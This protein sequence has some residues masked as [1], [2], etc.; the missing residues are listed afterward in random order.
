LARHDGLRTTRQRTVILDELRSR[1]T[2]P[3]ADELFR[4]VRRRLP[5][6]SLGTV[7]R[8]LE[9]LSEHGVIQRIDVPGG[10]RRFDGDTDGR[11]HIRCVA[12]GRV[13]DLHGRPPAG[14]EKAFRNRAGYKVLGHRVELLGLCPRC[15][16]SRP[17]P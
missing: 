7:Y 13:D 1:P 2:H 12:C 11:Y 15:Q 17:Q 10:Q 14:L 8:N 5:R 9:L 16:K 6:I 4:R 3:T